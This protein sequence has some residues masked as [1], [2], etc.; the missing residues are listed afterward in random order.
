MLCNKT[1]KYSS[2]RWKKKINKPFW[3][4]KDEVVYMHTSS[5]K[6]FGDKMLQSY[7]NGL[8]SLQIG[9][10]MMWNIYGGFY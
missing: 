1:D 3:Y 5:A 8:S 2:K 6:K 10:F 4:V 9:R 7:S